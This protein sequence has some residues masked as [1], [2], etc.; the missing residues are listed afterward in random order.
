MKKRDLQIV[1]ELNKVT[2][3]RKTFC[4]KV[5]IDDATCDFIYDTVRKM[6]TNKKVKGFS[7]FFLLLAMQLRITENTETT[8]VSKHL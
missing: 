1:L 2:I 5:M 4:T 8:F 7:R 3:N 6:E